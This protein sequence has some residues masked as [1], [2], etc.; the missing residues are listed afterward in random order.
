MDILLKIDTEQKFLFSP[1]QSDYAEKKLLKEKP[2]L[3]N[4][5]SIV[6]KRDDK[7]FIKS[8]AVIE[9]IKELKWYWKIFL[10]IKLIP[11]KTRDKLYNFIAR[12]RYDWFGK[13]EET[14]TP[15]EDAKSRFLME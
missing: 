9:I 2:A 1:L 13:R 10:F 14:R 7:Y 5:H 3:K 8:D 15:D 4:V 12:K 6:I 11:K